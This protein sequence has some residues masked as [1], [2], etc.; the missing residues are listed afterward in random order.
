LRDLKYFFLTNNLRLVEKLFSFEEIKTLLDMCN[1]S[2]STLYVSYLVNLLSIYTI[3]CDFWNLSVFWIITRCLVGSQIFFLDKQPETCQKKFQLWGNHNSLTHMQ[4]IRI[5][6]LCRICDGFR[7]FYDDILCYSEFECFWI[8]TRCLV[9]SQIFFL[10]KQSETCQN[11]FQLWGNHNSLWHIQYPRYQYFGPHIRIFHTI[12]HDYRGIWIWE[13]LDNHQ[14][15]CEISDIFPSTNHLRL[16]KK[17]STF[18]KSK[19]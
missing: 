17:I 14:A 4:F 2:E 11:K 10:D 13:F 12:P 8:I 1:I 5:V 3:Y 7:A 19:L 9:G 16:V 18:K 6:N 15:P